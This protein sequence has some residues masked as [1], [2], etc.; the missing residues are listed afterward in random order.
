MKNKPN[1]Q[2]QIKHE[3]EYIVFLQKRLNSNN[4]KSNSTP[5]EF[6][7]TKNKLDKAKLKLRLLKGEF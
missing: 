4:Y 7:K 6:Q 3:E 2:Q 1:K 5:E